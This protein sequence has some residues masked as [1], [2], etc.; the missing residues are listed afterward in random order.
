[1]LIGYVA[2]DD[3]L[4]SLRARLRRFAVNEPGN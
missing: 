1:L 4:G 2:L 3:D